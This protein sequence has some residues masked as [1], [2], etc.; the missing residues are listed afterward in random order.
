MT[1]GTC[2]KVT[3]LSI[4]MKRAGIVTILCLTALSA[5]AQQA[6]Q[7]I[8]HER[9]ECMWSGDEMFFAAT[10]TS[11]GEARAY[12]RQKGATEWCY[13]IGDRLTDRAFFIL[14]E[15]TDGVTLEYFFLS[16]INDVVTGRSDRIYEI[17][18]S[19]DC[20]RQPPRHETIVVSDC[21]TNG[22]IGTAVGAAL[23]IETDSALVEPSPFTPVQ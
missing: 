6:V 2:E 5:A 20:S 4:W 10:V 16:Q 13:V 18:L 1:N 14:P 12:Y 8:F 23:Q 7:P 19:D 3:L 9:P 11:D 15:F 17:A 22:G 21:E